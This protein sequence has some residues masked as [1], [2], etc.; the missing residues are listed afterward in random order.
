MIV[1]RHISIDNDCIRKME[2]FV[3]KHNGNFSAAM[4]DIIDHVGKSGLPNNSSAVDVSLFKWMLNMLD[5]VL[6]PDEVLDEMIDP[7]LINSIK[8]LEEHLSYRF[9]ELEWNTNLSI[10]C[11]ND[12]FPSDVMIEIKGDTHKIR[13]AACILCQY[14]VKNS[15]KQVP[16]EIKSV[17]NLNDCI[18]I[19]LIGSNKKEALN[20]LR[21]YFGEM[22]EVTCAIKSRPEFWKSLVN[23]HILSDYNM[24]TVHRN[25]FED[26]LANN[27]PLGEISIENIAKKPIEDIPLKEMLSLIKEVY[28]TSRVVDRVEIERD[29]IVLF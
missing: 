23:R 15:I 9:G 20:S 11:D 8:K 4:R 16:L 10:K 29:R 22:E 25:Y 6:V 17:L 26:L 7:V 1:T 14:M 3:A 19:E 5:C 27:I 13:F 24:V 2:P 28:E 21:T 18:K 12:R